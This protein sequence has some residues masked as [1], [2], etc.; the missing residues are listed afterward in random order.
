MVPTN[1]IIN[2]LKET[3]SKVK[4]K[5]QNFD[6]DKQLQQY[7]LTNKGIEIEKSLEKQRNLKKKKYELKE[8][9]YGKMCD[10]EIE[11]VFIKDIEWMAETKERVMERHERNLK[12]EQERKEKAEARK[13]YNEE[14]DR[15]RAEYEARQEERQKEQEKRRRAYEE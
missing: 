6:K 2:S 14:R 13:K 1:K 10:F 12:Y 4:S 5:E 15:K 7:D 8:E 9:F 11:Q 3:I